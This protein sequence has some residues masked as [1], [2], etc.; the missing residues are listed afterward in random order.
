MYFT[1][2]GFCSSLLHAAVGHPKIALVSGLLAVSGIVGVSTLPVAAGAER[3]LQLAE[4]RSMEENPALYA[5]AERVLLTFDEKSAGVDVRD[6][7]IQ[8]VL[9][10]LDCTEC[11]VE[12]IRDNPTLLN[13]VLRLYYADIHNRLGEKAA[14]AILE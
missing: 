11:S 5:I 9:N 1:G 13:G 6:S 8:Y 7:Q 12:D 10:L 4:E 2:A 3:T 14:L